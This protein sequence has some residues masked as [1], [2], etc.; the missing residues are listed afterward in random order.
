[1]A[2]DMSPDQPVE[3]FNPWTVVR[4]VFDHLA[5]DGLHPTLGEAGDPGAHAAG[6]L[7]ALGIRPTVEGDAR[8]SADVQDD[9]AQLR[10][11]MFEDD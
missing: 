5:A 9:L 8:T 4:L 7:R 3:T 11:I 1:M 2:A 6:L 10:S